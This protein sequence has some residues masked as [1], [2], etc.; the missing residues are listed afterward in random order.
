MLSLF[1]RSTQDSAGVGQS[2]FQNAKDLRKYL[3]Q[4]TLAI[5]YHDEGRNNKLIGYLMMYGT[6]LSRSMLPLC[7]AGY[8]VIDKFYRGMGLYNQILSFF[9]M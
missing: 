3:D 5:T 1:Q 2:E 4:A 9:V 8:G 6:P 7:G